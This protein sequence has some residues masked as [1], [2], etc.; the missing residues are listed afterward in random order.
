MCLHDV[1]SRYCGLQSIEVPVAECPCCGAEFR[2]LPS[3][4]VPYKQHAAGTLA[5]A[6]R[7][8]AAGRG[9]RGVAKSVGVAVS[10]LKRWWRW[11]RQVQ[12]VMW[13]QAQAKLRK[14]MSLEQWR[15]ESRLVR[16][17]VEFPRW[18]GPAQCR[19]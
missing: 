3:L 10:L 15:R 8:L 4:V 6:L 11:W 14:S 1:V 17:V 13:S 9:W 19:A 12:D 2:V 16:R 7:L 18:S 5:T